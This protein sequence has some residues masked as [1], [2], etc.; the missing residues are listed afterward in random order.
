MSFICGVHRCVM[1]TGSEDPRCSCSG[2]TRGI[3]SRALFP[4]TPEGTSSSS[5]LDRLQPLHR[6]SL[7][8]SGDAGIS[9]PPYVATSLTGSYISVVNRSVV[10]T[11]SE[12]LL[13]LLL[14]LLL[15]FLVDA[16]KHTVCTQVVLV[17]SQTRGGT[18]AALSLRRSDARAVVYRLTK[19]D[20]LRLQK[21]RRR[22]S[23]CP[24]F[25]C[26]SPSTREVALGM[27]SPHY[28]DGLLF[29]SNTTG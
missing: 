29:Q 4:P 10:F 22:R 1:F 9:P 21:K 7:R 14:L 15:L 19:P 6:D 23:C 8:P 16:K 5:P 26:S 11:G 17:L 20:H 18:S 12:A 13:L 2:S 24:V 25:L 28:D 3:T 27:F